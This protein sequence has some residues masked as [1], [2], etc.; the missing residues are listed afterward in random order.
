MY[1]II[2]LTL[3]IIITL[4]LIKSTSRIFSELS[5]PIPINGLEPPPGTYYCGIILDSSTK[6]S[7]DGSLGKE[8][9]LL[10]ESEKHVS[11]EDIKRIIEA[12]GIKISVLKLTFEDIKKLKTP[13]IAQ[14]KNN[15]F[16]VVEEFGEVYD[17]DKILI[18]DPRYGRVLLKNAH[19]KKIYGNFA[20]TV[21]K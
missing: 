3:S 13:F 15:Q 14:T 17:E 4:F 11:L 20:L 18:F 6:Y 1:K 9:S 16:L 2:T 21:V 19:F 10:L 7:E 8:I 12:K 5:D